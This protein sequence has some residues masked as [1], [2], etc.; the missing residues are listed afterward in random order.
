MV[1]QPAIEQKSVY[2]NDFGYAAEGSFCQELLELLKKHTEV[3]EK[4]RGVRIRMELDK[5]TEVD[6]DCMNIEATLEREHA[7]CSQAV[8]AL[9]TDHQAG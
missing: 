7:Q 9:P 8:P 4:V 5:Q 3:P 1:I 2:L 6:F